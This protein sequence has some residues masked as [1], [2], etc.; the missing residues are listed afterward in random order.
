MKFKWNSEQDKLLT[1]FSV[2]EVSEKLGI[3]KSK[4]Y[5]RI[6]YLVHK[7]Q[8]FSTVISSK[9]LSAGKKAALTRAKNKKAAEVLP[10]K[11]VGNY[12]FI[13]NGINIEISGNPKLI[14]TSKESMKIDY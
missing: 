13:I 4:I 8:G 1:S 5:G 7:G 14:L 12:K 2:K 11:Q 6:H 3:S 10:T 9:G